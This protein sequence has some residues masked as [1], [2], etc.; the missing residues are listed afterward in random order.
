MKQFK[1]ITMLLA[2][3]VSFTACEKDFLSPAPTSGVSSETYFSTEEELET[4]LI[5]MY[6]GIQGVNSTDPD[7][8]HG[9]QYEFYI[10]EMRSDNTRTKSSEGEAAQFESYNITPNNGIIA[11]YYE[12]YYNIIYRANVVLDNLD[13]IENAATK[14]SYE[15]EAKFVRAY[16]YFN[17]V[18]L[19]GDVPLIDRVVGPLETDIQFARVAASSIYDFIKSDLS[20]AVDGLDNTYRTRA[21]KAAAQTLLAKVYLTLGEN[22]SEAQTLLESV[23]ASGYSLEP[24]FEDVFYNEE[25]NEV[26]FSIGYLPNL[27]SDSQ[28][29]SAEWLNGVGRTSGVNYVTSEAVAVLD[30]FGGDRTA[31]SYRPDPS[32]VG[33]YQVTKYLPNGE[34][35]GSNGKSFDSD[36]TLAGNDWIVIRYADVLLLHVEAI[37][38]GSA[39]TTASKALTS[40]QAVRDRAGLTDPVTEVTKEDLLLERRVELAFENHRFF[41]LVRFGQAESVFSAFSSANN[42]GYSSTDL[43]LPI[44]QNEI[45]LSNGSMSQNPGY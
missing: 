40:F 39:S 30:E 15:A 16:A 27:S 29:F 8:R 1:L 24:D 25:N 20:T 34:D 28:N 7:D 3:V 5:N 26:I 45:N 21:S 18:R 32:Q 13:V 33:Q 6:D 22:Y 35:G 17:L 4:A 42:L 43:L 14:A 10:T 12:S 41:D 31:V 23:M 38:A 2:V 11:N 36:P 37:M 44:P 9:I 19:Y